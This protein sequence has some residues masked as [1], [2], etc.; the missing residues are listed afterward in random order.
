LGSGV[1][2]KDNINLGRWSVIGAGSVLLSNA[3]EFSTYVGIP[4]KFKK[5][6]K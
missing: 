1:T 6:L 5:R 2:L 3:K 4:A